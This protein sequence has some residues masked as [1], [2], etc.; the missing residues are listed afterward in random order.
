[1]RGNPDA[2]V[3]AI[4]TGLTVAEVDVAEHVGLHTG[5]AE[6]VRVANSLPAQW[7]LGCLP[8][9][10]ADRRCGEGD[11]FEHADCVIGVESA[12][13]SSRFDFYQVLWH[14]CTERGCRSE[15]GESG[16]A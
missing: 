11:A 3:Q 1:M 6:F 7:R 2:E 4:F 13:N 9:E 16:D 15:A 10:V 14:S 5:R 8:A 12:F